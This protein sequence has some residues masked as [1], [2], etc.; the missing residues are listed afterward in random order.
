MLSIKSIDKFFG[1][2]QVL[3]GI[4][5]DLMPGKA[6]LIIG[7]SGSGKTVLMKCLAGLLTPEN[8]EIL[9]DGRPFDERHDPKTVN[10]I[11]RDIGMVFQGGA[12]FDSQTVLENVVFPLDMFSRMT[13]AEKHDRAHD[14]LKR[15]GLEDVDRLYPSELSGGMRKR[16]AIA[17]AI[18]NNP[19][20]LFCDEPNS[21][22]DPQT[23]ARIDALIAEIT[24]EYQTTT[25]INTHDM[26]SVLQYGDLVHF[27]F[28]GKRWWTGNRHTILE[29][30]DPELRRF[31]EAS[32]LTK[33][34]LHA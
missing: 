19:K 21:G 8:G 12:L 23:S 26:N 14:C 30:D 13:R 32:E 10:E 7:R 28:E 6:N 31:L 20:Y 25:V 11:R 24:E 17:R 29:A 18:V 3:F 22:L 9:F 16:V 15:V 5:M 1:E 27:I 4:T 2:R 33:R 34:L